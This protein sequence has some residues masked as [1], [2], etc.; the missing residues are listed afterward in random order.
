MAALTDLGM[1]RRDFLRFGAAGF[2]A[3]LGGM[4]L[5]G[6]GRA[7]SGEVPAPPPSTLSRDPTPIERLGSLLPPDANGVCL[8][9]GFASRIVARSGQAPVSGK[10]YL[11][12]SAPDGGAVF[13]GPAGGWIYVS[14]SEMPS[15]AGGVGALR[16]DAAGNAVDAYPILAGTS[17]NCAGGRAPW[18]R[19]LSC[20]ENGDGGQVFECDPYGDVAPIARPALGRFNHEAVAFD[21]DTGVVYMSEDRRDGGFYR[22]I[23]SPDLASGQLQVARVLGGGI[24]GPVAWSNVPDP[25][26]AVT[27][28]RKQ[29]AG[30]TRFNG[31]EG[32]AC[33]NGVVYL[34]TKGDNR[35]WA[36]DIA[37]SAIVILYDLAKAVHPILSGVDNIEM[38]ADGDV[39]VA[40]DGGDMQIVAITPSGKTVAVAQV[41]GHVSSEITGPAFTP[42]GTRLYFSSQRGATGA[43][44]DG[45]TF[46]IT[47]PFRA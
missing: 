40:E 20:E 6:C 1:K 28:T 26:G 44:A 21:V 7:G 42:D 23:P 33:R 12:H 5:P 2:S 10:P 43:S 17:Q 37:S 13:D 24:E 15:G 19:W 29:V 4:V 25:S 39:L 35:I 3:F 22:Y 16:F 38:T 31:G 41:P 32:M 18:S 34:A 27:A 8:P 30:M 9:P 47:G 14:N 36:Y 45:V 11:W 46:E